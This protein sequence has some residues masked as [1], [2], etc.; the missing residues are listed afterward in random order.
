MTSERKRVLE[1][2]DLVARDLDEIDEQE[3]VGEVDG[4]T[5]ARLRAAYRAELESLDATLADLPDDSDDVPEAPTPTD[6]DPSQATRSVRSVVMASIAIVAVLSVVIFIAAQG[7]DDDITASDESPGALTVDPAAVS[8]EQLEAIVAGSPDV[9]GM[10]MALADRYFSAEDYGS[11]LDHYLYIA[12]NAEDAIDQSQALARVGWMAYRT[13]LP[14]EAADYVETSL[15]LDPVNNEAILY[16]GFITFYGLGDA[17][18][19]IPQLEDAFELPN[20]SE[21]VITQIVDALDEAR[22]ETP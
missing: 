10:R 11:A 5:A 2:R 17:E 13:G 18:T 3:E 1:R 12:E 22:G 15:Q 21:S 16:R 20:L 19:A 14:G 6:D 9:T 8:N 7:G 4:E